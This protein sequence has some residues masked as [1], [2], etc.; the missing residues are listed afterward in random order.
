MEELYTRKQMENAVM[1]AADLYQRMCEGPAVDGG[2]LEVA[3]AIIDEAVKM[4][5]WLTEKYGEDDDC[6]LDRLD[7]YEGMM[8]EKYGLRLP[9]VTEP[10]EADFYSV[11][12]DGQGGRQIHIFGF[13]TCCEDMGEGAWRNVEYTGFIEPLSEFI[14]H[15]K[16]DEDYVDNKA[17]ELNE[18]VGE[19]NDEEMADIINHYFNGHTADRRLA[20]AEITMDTP[21]GN[22][23]A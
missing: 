14:E 19:Y 15:L 11:E 23:I 12:P 9:E 18:Y 3:G 10:E 21:C 20:Y 17:L 8:V 6:Y 22:Y 7:E 2:A 16:Q 4:E 1:L 13:C 5:A